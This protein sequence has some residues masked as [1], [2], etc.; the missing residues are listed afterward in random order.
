MKVFARA[1][2]AAVVALAMSSA[3][4]SAATAPS[5]VNSLKA[6]PGD[7]QVTL[8]WTSP[9][10]GKPVTSY[11]VTAS[12]GGYSTTDT[13]EPRTVSNLKNGTLY[14]FTV[15]ANNAAGQGAKSSVTA[16]PKAIP[17]S[18]PQNLGA[19]DLGSG[20][21][22]L[23]WTPPA[24]N[25]SSPDG[26]SPNLSRYNITIN[27]GGT[28]TQVP[29]NTLTYTASNIPANV[30]YTFSVSA[31]NSRSLTGPAATV[32]APL[33][34]G[35]TIGL[36]PTA[37]Q[38]TTSLT[39]TGQLFLKNESLTLY[40]DL[41]THIAATLV[42]DDNGA[43]TR[44]LKPRP[45]DTPKVHKLCASVQPKPCANFTLQAPPTPI[46]AVTPSP[47]ETPTPS[48]T[49]S[50]QASG[51]RAG[52]N[53]G[54][55]GLDIITRPP[56]VFLPILGILGLLGVLAFW[57]LTG[58][59]RPP[60]PAAAT[61]V[62]RATRPDYMAPFPARGGPVSAPGGLPAGGLPPGGQPPAQPAWS[63][64]IQQPLPPPVQ[65]PPSLQP[66]PAAQPAPPA[67]P[68]APPAPRPA[69]P[70]APVEWPNPPGWVPDEPPDLPQP[71]D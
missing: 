19:T 43:F 18:A 56:F 4:V 6:T 66:P 42:T 23:D 45:L 31:T 38:L 33:P 13:S 41:P 7:T 27:P 47:D 5:K 26:T 17:P 57:A 20:Q 58:R 14:T 35:A 61:V 10:I 48:P 2:I 24:T 46:A 21:I 15:W 55:S 68:P 36:Q 16:T 9:T 59:R 39:V 69:A 30:T 34:S 60:A 25:G 22:R 29:A 51:V 53:G 44:V 11:T 52:G 62:H 70:Q 8:S 12:P 65:L 67:P 50:P 3:S 49:D 28:R 71:S 1:V 54:L 40:W 64:P 32:Y 37:G 63:A